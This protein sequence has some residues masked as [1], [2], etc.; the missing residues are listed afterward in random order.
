MGFFT[1]SG[2]NAILIA[3]TGAGGMI[4]FARNFY[5]MSLGERTV[6]VL[7]VLVIVSAIVISQ[8]RTALMSLLGVIILEVF[9]FYRA[10]L[11]CRILTAFLIMSLVGLCVVG[12]FLVNVK[13]PSAEGR[14]FLWSLST[15]MIIENPLTG[16]G[17][18]N[19]QYAFNEAQADYF[20]ENPE[21]IFLNRAGDISN[22]FNDYIYIAAERG[23]FSGFQIIVIIAGAVYLSYRSRASI[24]SSLLVLSLCALGSYSFSYSGLK[25]LFV[26][27]WAISSLQIPA[28][29]REVKINTFIP[30]VVFAVAFSISFLTYRSWIYAHELV[31]RNSE[32]ANAEYRHLYPVL[33]FDKDFH[34]EYGADLISMGKIDEGITQLQQATKYNNS[35]DLFLMLGEGYDVQGR[36]KLSQ[37]YYREAAAIRPGHLQTLYLLMDSFSRQQKTGSANLMAKRI[38]STEHLERNKVTRQ[39]LTAARNQLSTYKNQQK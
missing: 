12:Y 33:Q 13:R 38:L 26:T 7:S 23:I 25:V 3:V 22:P 19:F 21:S 18:D 27:Y 9:L 24:A 16:V 8:S 4:W 17:L 5:D 11:S 32:A 36:F 2:F 31:F 37:Y 1:N 34:F 29:H 14:F 30:G 39:I 15:S 20:K 6:A 10:R 35:P 28:K